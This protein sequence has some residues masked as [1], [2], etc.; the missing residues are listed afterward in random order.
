VVKL[1]PGRTYYFS[2]QERGGKWIT[3]MTNNQPVAEVTVKTDGL[4]P[5]K[6]EYR[7]PT[8]APQ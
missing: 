7:T 3:A 1:N 4:V 5:L 8:D 2:W 6:Y